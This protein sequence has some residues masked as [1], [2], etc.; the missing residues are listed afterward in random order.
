MK[1]NQTS[2]W[3]AIPGTLKAA[4]C[5]AA[6]GAL[7]TAAPVMAEISVSGQSDTIFRMGQSLDNKKLYPAYEYLRLSAI[8]S[9]K[10]GGAVSVHVG[11]WAR[12]DLGDKSA[13]NRDTDADLQYGFISYQGAKNNLLINAGRQFV[14]EG[15]AA[16]RLDGLYARNDFAA[17]FG[18]AAYLGSPVVTEP[19]LKADEF[20]FGGRVTH[21]LYKYYTV[22]LSALRSFDD[23]GIVYREEEGF[24]V[25]AHPIKQID[26]TGRSAYNSVTEGWMEHAYAVSYVPVESLRVGAD[27]SYTS[28]Q[29]YFYRVT[30]SALSFGS[31]DRA[32]KVTTFGG[33]IAY[34]PVS[35]FTIAA[36]YKNYDYD[37][38]RTADYYGVKATL[39]LPESYSAGLSVH[40][41]DG[42]VSKLK[43]NEVRLFASK[44]IAHLNLAADFINLNY[45]QAINGVSKTYTIVGSASYELSES[46]KIGADIDWSKNPDFQNEVKGLV[47]LTYAF[48]TKRAAEGRS[49]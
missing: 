41:M 22:G 2:K 15:V 5:L 8:K 33:S 19:N 36:D 21:S 44:N 12:G 29:D 1:I 14:S 7:L 9:E 25:W 35:T 46:L 37:I 28:Y 17:G 20:I 43:Y 47:K 39:Y 30:T 18:A 40:R 45:D 6:T 13:R 48:D 32:E 42:A 31:I 4:G 27:Y 26:I 34:T 38:A 3:F 49:K 10:D 11:G 24:D 16:Q 23:N